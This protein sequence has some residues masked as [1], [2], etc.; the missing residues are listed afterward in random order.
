MNGDGFVDLAEFQA[1]RPEFTIEK[2]NA[3][4][5]NKD[6]LLSR[7]EMDGARGEAPQEQPNGG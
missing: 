5:A 3:A 2:F 1:V 6:G 7:D 4:D